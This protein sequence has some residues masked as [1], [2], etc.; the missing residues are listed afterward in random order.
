MRRNVYLAVS[1]HG[2]N[3]FVRAVKENVEIYDPDIVKV[4]NIDGTYFDVVREGFNGDIKLHLPALNGDGM[5]NN[6]LN[7]VVN[8]PEHI[9][10]VFTD[11]GTKGWTIYGLD[12]FCTKHNIKNP[13]TESS[14]KKMINKMMHY[15]GFRK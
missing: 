10:A 15:I 4:V 7:Q 6:G 13:T 9:V 1:I 8:D 12:E 3:T 5:A 2:T 11:L 14:W